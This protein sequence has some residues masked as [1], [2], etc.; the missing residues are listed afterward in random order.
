MPELLSVH[1]QVTVV[2][3]HVVVTPLT[4]TGH[5]KLPW[6]EPVPSPGE[7]V[8]DFGVGVA[9]GARQLPTTLAHSILSEHLPSEGQY[10]VP[11]GQQCFDCP[12][13]FPQKSY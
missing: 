11:A 5:D 9:V 8:V 12:E 4:D 10:C 7:G 3:E 2:P 6:P 13:T 1:L